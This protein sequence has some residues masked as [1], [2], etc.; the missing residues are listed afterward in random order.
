MMDAL[1]IH[2]LSRTLAWL[3]LEGD[4]TTALLRGIMKSDV[5]LFR[6]V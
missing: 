5:Q 6:I 3:N 1:S 2:S 4:K